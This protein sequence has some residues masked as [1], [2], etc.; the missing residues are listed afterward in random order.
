MGEALGGQFQG[1]LLFHILGWGPLFERGSWM[2]FESISGDAENTQTS[3]GISR[4]SVIKV[5]AHAAW[6]V[7]LVQVVAAAPACRRVRAPA[8]LTSPA[9][10]TW[11]R[12]AINSHWT[13][14]IV[15]VT[16]TG[17]RQPRYVTVVSLHVPGWLLPAV[18]NQ[19]PTGW[20]AVRQRD[21]GDVSR[22]SI[23]FS[24][25][26][27]GG[28][29][30]MFTAVL[31]LAKASNRGNECTAWRLRTASASGGPRTPGT[32]RRSLKS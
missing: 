3:G 17:E 7:P 21:A 23:A 8:V 2:T 28:A 30:V 19:S 15:T 12:P 5:G 10:A 16:N 29:A 32:H 24:S 26:W 1:E 4:R 18:G 31:D 20:A 25:H 6:A 22:C 13:L 27:H 9:A 11:L 14:T